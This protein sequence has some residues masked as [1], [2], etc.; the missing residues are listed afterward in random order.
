[1][2]SAVGGVFNSISLCDLCALS[3]S[4]VSGCRVFIYHRDTEDTKV[5]QR[6]DRK[7]RRYREKA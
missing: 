3:V 6:E 2:R 5:A 7:L 4:V 1:M